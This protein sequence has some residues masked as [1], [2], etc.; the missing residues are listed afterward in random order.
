MITFLDRLRRFPYVLEL[1]EKFTDRENVKSYSS[2]VSE[3][4]CD[5][6]KL[7][8]VLRGMEIRSG[9]AEKDRHD[10][11]GRVGELSISFF[12]LVYS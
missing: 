1:I 5:K 3:F 4:L 7:V 12:S 11:K 6:E 8:S 9:R 2:V 10:L